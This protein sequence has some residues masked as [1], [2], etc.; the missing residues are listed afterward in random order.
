MRAQREKRWWCPAH[1]VC[2]G[3]CVC[4][5]NEDYSWSKQRYGEELARRWERLETRAGCPGCLSVRIC[6]PPEG[7][8]SEGRGV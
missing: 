5:D 7:S 3:V 4:G 1:L 8:S 6:V 2:V